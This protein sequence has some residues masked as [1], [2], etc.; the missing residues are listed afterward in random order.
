MSGQR[1]SNV[2]L[3]ARFFT[4]G[5]GFFSVWLFPIECYAYVDPN[6]AGWL[7][8]FLFPLLV[9]VCGVWA[10]FRQR[11]RALWHRLFRRGDKRE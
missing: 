7:F 9:A 1:M 4:S 11:I 5:L 2:K 10:I 3:K 8:Q 6:A